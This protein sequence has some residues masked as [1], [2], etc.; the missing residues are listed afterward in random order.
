MA[1]MIHRGVR[2]IILGSGL[3]LLAQAQ[4]VKL[5]P[6]KGRDEFARVCGAC[7][8]TDVAAKQKMDPDQWAATV[9]HMVELGAEGTDD[10]FKSIVQY[11]SKNFS[12]SKP[13]AADTK[14]NVNTAD[15]AQ[16]VSGLELAQADAEAIVRYR[17]DKGDFKNWSDLGKVPGIDRKK[18]ENEKNRIVF[19]N[20]DPSPEDRK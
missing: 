5:P 14:I 13:P 9:D 8:L 15:S 20:A 18:L 11:L 3:I 12:L 10:E 17:K 16:L 1:V 7:H 6:G 4:S 2:G 19:A